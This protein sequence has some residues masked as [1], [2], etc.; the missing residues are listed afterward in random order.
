M[1]LIHHLVA[2]LWQYGVS[3][4]C[5]INGDC[6]GQG[7]VITIFWILWTG[8]CILLCRHSV[9]AAWRDYHEAIARAVPITLGWWVLGAEPIREPATVRIGG[10]WFLAWLVVGFIG[11]AM[12]GGGM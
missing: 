7:A 6:G 5:R 10:G 1:C 11:E 4:R 12:I 9:R 8:G 3:V 2:Y